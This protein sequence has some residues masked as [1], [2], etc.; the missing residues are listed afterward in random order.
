MI[1]TIVG[2]IIANILLL[3]V[4]WLRRDWLLGKVLNTNAIHSYMQNVIDGAGGAISKGI[5]ELF[6]DPTVKKAYSY[7]QSQSTEA[8]IDK[9][10][11][12]EILGAVIDNQ[13]PEIRAFLQMIGQEHWMENP[14]QLLT[15]YAKYKPFI[16]GLMGR[17][18]GK[19]QT[20][21]TG[22]PWVK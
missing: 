1:Y 18:A 21:T 7:M 22:H 8:K 4:V 12:K 20:G 9:K 11:E 17:Q 5:Q 19:P 10:A 14:E 13:A 15:L 6:T 2:V 3:S 16:D